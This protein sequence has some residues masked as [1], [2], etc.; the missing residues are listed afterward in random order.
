MVLTSSTVQLL[1]GLF[2]DLLFGRLGFSESYIGLDVPACK[3]LGQQLLVV[4]VLDG[5]WALA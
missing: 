5:E 2:L 1:T 3:T 4:L